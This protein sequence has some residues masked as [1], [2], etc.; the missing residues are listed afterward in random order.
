MRRI[1][2]VLVVLAALVVIWYLAAIPM[3]AR[4]TLA[5]AE[6]AGTELT[7]AEVVRDTMNQERPRLPLPHQVG[8][9]LWKSVVEKLPVMARAIPSAPLSAASYADRPPHAFS[10]SILRRASSRRGWQKG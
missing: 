2:P 4:W 7:F 9:E 8:D 10:Q 6:R 1:G 5:Q 3:N